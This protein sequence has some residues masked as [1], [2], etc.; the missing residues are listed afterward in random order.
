MIGYGGRTRTR[1]EIFNI[2]YP[3][4]LIAQS[5]VSKVDKKFRTITRRISLELLI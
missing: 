5:T 2:E 1:Q 3:N 4:K